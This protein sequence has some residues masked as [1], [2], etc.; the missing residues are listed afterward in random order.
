M[1]AS[2]AATRLQHLYEGFEAGGVTIELAGQQDAVEAMGMQRLGDGRGQLA[3]RLD[4]GGLVA[5]EGHDGTR[6]GEGVDRQVER[7]RGRGQLRRST[8]VCCPSGHG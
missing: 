1:E 2:A 5:Q 4:V 7:V 8:H 6:L 3:Q